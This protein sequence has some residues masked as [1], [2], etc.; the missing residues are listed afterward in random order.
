MKR[1]DRYCDTYMTEC[2]VC[3]LNNLAHICDSETWTEEQRQILHLFLK[4]RGY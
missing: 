1:L 4:E 2:D 3:P